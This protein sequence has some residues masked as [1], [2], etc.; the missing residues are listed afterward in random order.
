MWGPA[1]RG[2]TNATRLATVVA[3]AATLVSPLA[4]HHRYDS[5]D[6]DDTPEVRQPTTVK[7]VNQGF[8][9]MTIYVAQTG[10][11][12]IRLG[13]ATGNSSST[14]VIPRSIVNGGATT[15]LFVADPIGG[16]RPSVSDQITVSPG[17]NVQL[18]IPP[19]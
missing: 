14:F 7:V 18:T 6:P 3:L 4:C 1:R 9:D 8:P 12:R 17:D 19:Y 2:R 5:K 15:L 16:V 11:Q 13:L 10:G